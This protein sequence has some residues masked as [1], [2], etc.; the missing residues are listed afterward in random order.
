LYSGRPQRSLEVQRRALELGLSILIC[1]RVRL[2]LEN[3]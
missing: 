1:A 2:F 3:P